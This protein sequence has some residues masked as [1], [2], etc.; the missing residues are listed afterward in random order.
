[1]RLGG[2][3]CAAV[4]A[5]AYSILWRV[6]VAFIFYAAHERAPVCA[7]TARAGGIAVPADGYGDRKCIFLY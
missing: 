7:V 1:V 5:G 6:L 4:G 3:L 2:T